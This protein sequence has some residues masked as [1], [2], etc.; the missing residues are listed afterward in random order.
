MKTLVTVL[1][2]MLFV[3]PGIQ[4]Q[5]SDFQVKKKFEGEVEAIRTAIDSAETIGRLDSLRQRIDFLEA[6][7]SGR[8]MF[9]DRALYPK[10]YD[11][12]VQE[13][14]TAHQVAHDRV[15]TIESQGSRIAEIEGTLGGMVG[16]LDSL[17]EERTKLFGELQSM[18]KSNQQLQATLKRLNTTLQARD[19]LIFALVDSVFVPYSGNIQES[20][21]E[22]LG[23]TL[24]RV[25]VVGRIAD[26]AADNM[27]FVEATQLE[28]K[29]FGSVLDQYQTFR[30]RW[31]GLRDMINEAYA[32]VEAARRRTA[33]AGKETPNIQETLEVPSARVD[34]VMA[35]WNRRVN[36]AIWAGVA[37]EFNA[38]SI[39]LAPFSDGA[40][41]S[42][43]IRAYVDTLKTKQ[44]DATVFVDVWRDRIDKEWRDALTREVVLGRA[45][46]ADL[47]KAVS[48]LGGKKFDGTIIAILIGIVVVAGGG[49]WLLN[50]RTK[51]EPA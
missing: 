24:D 43:S 23:K 16:S 40:S 32:R 10:T 7:Y 18:R 22:G 13:L 30:N 4:G 42:E 35:A 14:R 8:R 1:G 2:I 37:K 44:A 49:W 3:S 33:A 15:T 25:D 47:D 5:T 50:R 51:E 9:L 34:S 12:L 29:D 27:R 36:D 21:V 26:V 17:R 11:G 41:F 48:E 31:N 46:Y 45:E 19:K 20:Q 28:G 39:Y 6:E 38:R